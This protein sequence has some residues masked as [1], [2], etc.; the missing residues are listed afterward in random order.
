[1]SYKL[2]SG[3]QVH[4][5]VSYV[6]ASGNPATVDGAVSWDSSDHSIVEVHTDET[7]STKCTVMANGPVGQAQVSATADADLGEGTR[8][9]TTIMDVE[10][11]AGEA[12]AGTIEPVGGAEPI[13]KGR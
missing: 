5:G 1:M 8:A 11:I 10:V 12:V 6:D 3:M 2:A 9:I 4:V 7:D 13:P